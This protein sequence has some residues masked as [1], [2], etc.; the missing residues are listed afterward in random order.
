MGKRKAAPGQ[1]APHFWHLALYSHLPK[2]PAPV[3]SPPTPSRPA[4]ALQ[5]ACGLVSWLLGMKSLLCFS[6]LSPKEGWIPGPQWSRGFLHGVPGPRLLGG[7]ESQPSSA[8]GILV[9]VWGHLSCQSLSI[10]DKGNP[11][12]FIL[13]YF[14]D[15]G[16]WVFWRWMLK[17]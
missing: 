7:W 15:D 4:L 2:H 9:C 6:L 10:L 13:S 1:H 17:L 16:S 5:P 3:Q 8:G 14:V 12:L 11:D